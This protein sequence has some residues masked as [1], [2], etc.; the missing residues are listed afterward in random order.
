MD[1]HKIITT[2]PDHRLDDVRIT[3]G[4]EMEV[5]SYRC[6]VS[7]G[8]HSRDGLPFLITHRNLPIEW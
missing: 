1:R 3:L 5:V 7:L 6:R 8:G 2:D 4:V